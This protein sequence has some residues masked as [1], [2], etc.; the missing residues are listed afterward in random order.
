M[1]T[2]VVFGQATGNSRPYLCLP[3]EGLDNFFVSQE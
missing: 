2:C 3:M 1:G